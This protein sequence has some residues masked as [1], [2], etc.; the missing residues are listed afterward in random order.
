[1]AGRAT[2][3]LNGVP[4]VPLGGAALPAG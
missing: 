4:R 3:S 2:G 1:M